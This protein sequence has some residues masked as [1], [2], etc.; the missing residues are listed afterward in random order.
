MKSWACSVKQKL[1]DATLARRL[2]NTAR[3]GGYFAAARARFEAEGDWTL[4]EISARLV[5]AAY[6]LLGDR[7][8]LARV[9]W[10]WERMRPV[11]NPCRK[12]SDCKE[13]RV[14]AAANLEVVIDKRARR[15]KWK[16][17]MRDEE[18]N[19]PDGA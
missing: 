15:L 18:L 3:V 11:V 4:S 10:S 9:K 14:R 8:P 6:T 12:K 17:E 16:Q 2:L 5:D 1:T 13:W 19:G 7:Y